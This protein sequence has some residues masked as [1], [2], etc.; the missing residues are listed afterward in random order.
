ML[1]TDTLY[2]FVVTLRSGKH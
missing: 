2:L 1:F